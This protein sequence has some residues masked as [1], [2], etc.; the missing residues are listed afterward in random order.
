MLPCFNAAPTLAEA[1]DSIRAQTWKDWELIVLDDGSS[2][3]SVRIA[4]AIAASEPRVRVVRSEH[5][6]IVKALQRACGDA[7]GDYIAR[8]DADDLAAPT[9]LAKQTALMNREPHVALSG[10]LIE[11]Y[12]A[13]IGQGRRR[14]EKWING[15]L[16]HEDIVRELFIE[17]PLPHPT[18]MMRR[19]A[20][21]TIGGY[22]DHGWP[23]DYDLCMRIFCAGA[24]FAKVPEML[25]KW[26]ERPQRLSMTDPR[27]SDA[28]FRALKRHYLFRSYL[29]GRP[30]FHQWGAGE[31]GKRWLRE[32]TD[33]SPAAVVDINP[34]KVGSTIHGIPVIAPQ[35]L[36]PPGESYV[37]IAVG[38]RGARDEIRAW[39]NPRGHKELDHYLFIA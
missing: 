18:F 29:K 19:E 9:R 24:R 16:S 28:S 32:W 7:R 15:L 25:L 38:A 14:Y 39:L 33:P 1:I 26:R 5:V 22:Q 6:G 4:E 23:E 30:S 34:R 13:P 2:D 36:P 11:M 27:Y 31:V 3:N 10:T 21:D 12:G 37:V 17:C 20:F 8:M 35:D